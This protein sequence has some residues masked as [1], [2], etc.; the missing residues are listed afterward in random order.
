MDLALFCSIAGTISLLLVYWYLYIMYHERYMGMWIASWLGFA[1]RIVLFDSGLIEWKESI[2]GFII[3]QAMY[4]STILLFLWSTCLFSSRPYKQW[5]IYCGIGSFILSILFDVLHL[6]LIYIMAPSALFAGIILIYIGKMFMYN[7]LQVNG[8]GNY[9]AGYSFILWGAFTIIMP[10]S[11]SIATPWPYLI[12]GVLRLIIASATLMVFF[13]KTKLELT[14]KEAQYRLLVENSVDVIY[15]YSLLPEPKFDYLSPAMAKVTGY[16]PEEFYA[17]AELLNR[18]IHPDDLPRYTQFISNH[19]PHKPFTFRLTRK[20]RNM[21]W[22]ELEFIDIYTATGDIL[23]QQGILREVTARI[24]SEQLATQNERLNM[25]GQMAV[26]FAHEIRNPLTTVCGYLQILSRKKQECSSCRERFALMIK[27]L[28]HASTIISE[29]L[30]LAQDKQADRKKCCLNTIIEE[31]FPLM[32]ADATASSVVVN[33]DLKSIPQ[34]FLDQNEIRKLLLNLVRNGVEAMP[35]G[36]NLTIGTNFE[37]DKVVLSVGDQGVGIPTEILEDLGKP[38]LTT[39]AMGMG[40]GLP[41]CYR[42]A[43]RHNAT[44]NVK[45]GGQGTTFFIC[46]TPSPYAA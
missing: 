40:L 45:T 46:F 14:N 41:I 13:E 27:E 29:Y 1:L 16:C 42:I 6:P 35:K 30:L 32:Q 11:S 8:L 26:S 38:F 17:D 7:N 18:L 28:N 10:Y 36:G 22:I 21:I 3:F 15:R 19:F 34:L 39:K 9:I 4:V 43:N 5:W 25:V 44:I 31:V 20:D 37:R 23:A 12:C 24:H 2:A 33:L